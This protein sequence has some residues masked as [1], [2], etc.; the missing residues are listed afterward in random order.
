[1]VRKGCFD[2]TLLKTNTNFLCIS[3]VALKYMRSRLPT[4]RSWTFIFYFLF[5][6]YLIYS[7]EFINIEFIYH[8]LFHSPNQEVANQSTSLYPVSIPIALYNKRQYLP[9]SM[10][11]ILN[12]TLKN[13]EIIICDD[14]S[15]DGSYEYVQNLS[16]ID[17]RINII[18]FEQNQ[19]AYVARITAVRHSH[20][21]FIFFCD[22]DDRVAPEAAES[23]YNL[24]IQT[25]A[26]IVEHIEEYIRGKR[27]SIFPW[28][29]PNFT[30]AY[31][32]TIVKEFLANRLNWNLH[33]K[34]IRRTVFLRAIDI[35]EEDL[36]DK[37]LVISEDLLLFGPIYMLTKKMVV[38]PRILYYYYHNPRSN[39]KARIKE[40][41]TREK[42]QSIVNKRL[43]QI[44]GQ[45]V[46]F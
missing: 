12:Q 16:L 35:I 19:G 4:K 20:G 41:G 42:Q 32:D 3:L 31:T 40:L 46:R 7:H 5:I 24:A 36:P 8:I 2:E 15:T 38:N 9:R 28:N 44:F 25:G 33:R 43:S 34:I 17:K 27:H 14:G 39:S 22:A 26:D 29:P 13:I 6:I 23:D 10:G 21:E 30:V 18:R 11:S 1:M 45:D 37:F